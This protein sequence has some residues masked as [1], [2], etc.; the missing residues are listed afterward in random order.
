MDGH[1]R[2]DH[3]TMG[4][5]PVTNPLRAFAELIEAVRQE[6]PYVLGREVWHL[7]DPRGLLCRNTQL[8]E[9]CYDGNDHDVTA[10]GIRF[11]R[12]CQRIA[13]AANG[14]PTEALQE[15]R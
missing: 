2:K 1:Q 6:R 12:N 15:N 8:Q 3:L 5:D 14:V 7:T 10:S 11:C 9:A 13:N 4:T